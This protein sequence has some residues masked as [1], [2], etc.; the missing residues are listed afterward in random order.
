[1]TADRTDIRDADIQ[2]S[3]EVDEWII[4]VL[5]RAGVKVHVFGSDHGIGLVDV[6]NKWARVIDALSAGIHAAAR[7]EKLPTITP[8]E[9]GS[10]SGA[11]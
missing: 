2:L 7:G 5:R 11:L 4:A 6:P 10:Q 8:D 9:T 1:M 3:R